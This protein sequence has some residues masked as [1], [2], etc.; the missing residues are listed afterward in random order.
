M[1]LESWDYMKKKMLFI[2]NPNAGKGQ[3]KGKLSDVVEIF[4]KAEYEVTIYSTRAKRD[5]IKIIVDSKIDYDL[6]VC[7]G[8]D[9]TLN[10]VTAGVMMKKNRPR[11]GYL[12]TGTTNDFA[13]SHKIPKNILKAANVAVSGLPYLFDIGSLNDEFFTYVA[14]FGAFTEV[15]YETPQTYKNIFGRVAY[16]LEG[17]K[18][19]PSL[20]SYQMT[21]QYNDQIIED[22]FIFGMITNSGTVGGFK[23]FSGNEILLDDGL[24]EVCLIKNPKNPIELQTIINTLI[25]KDGSSNLIYTFRVKQISFVAKESVPWTLDGEFGG[26]YNEVKVVNYKQAISYLIDPKKHVIQK[27][28]KDKDDPSL[29]E[30]K[31]S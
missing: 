29:I 2:Y 6:I 10:E 1:L 21:A 31:N 17:M 26:S 9:G 18:R 8:G 24:F 5:A 30:D 25:T 27:K 12:P 7:S 3:I 4:V 19:L 20:K 11:I 14:A 28:G 13:F 16:L 15:S 23:G 22:E